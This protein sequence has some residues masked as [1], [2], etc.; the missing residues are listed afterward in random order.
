L[1]EGGGGDDDDASGGSDLMTHDEAIQRV[2]PSMGRVWNRQERESLNRLKEELR[3]SAEHYAQKSVHAYDIGENDFTPVLLEYNLRNSLAYLAFQTPFMHAPLYKILCEIRNRMDWSWKP[4]TVFDF[5][6]GPAT[7]L[8]TSWQV[9]V[10]EMEERRVNRSAIEN[11]ARA[12]G[13]KKDQLYPFPPD[14]LP[15]SIEYM[16]GVDASES[17]IKLA[18]LLT[19]ANDECGGGV[20]G[21]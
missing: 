7:G 8:W 3:K 19:T 13:I 6:C 18:K 1:V 20:K 15:K 9:F 16:H 21:K 2:M 10:Q 12:K 11:D 5:G 14:H 17:M 4:R